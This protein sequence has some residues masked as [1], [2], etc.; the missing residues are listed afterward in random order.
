[1]S[2]TILQRDLTAPNTD[3]TEYHPYFP[4]TDET[5]MSLRSFEGTLYAV[6]SLVLRTSSRFFDTMFTLP[7]PL[8]NLETPLVLDVYESD[9]TLPIILSLLIGSTPSPQ[10]WYNCL[11]QVENVLVVA[12]KWEA[13]DLIEQIRSIL[14]NT[15][16]PPP[17][18]DHDHDATSLRLYAIARHFEWHDEAQKIVPH[19][20]TLDLRNPRYS[21][22]LSRISSKYLVP[23]MDLHQRRKEMFRTSLDSP[24]RFTAGDR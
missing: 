23:L 9:T 1:M 4:I 10:T 11:N 5:D 21:T 2:T 17:K 3:W 18:D 15:H 14:F 20:L 7:Q 13:P 16:S 8:L 12:E 19:T 24:Q 22:L 6:R